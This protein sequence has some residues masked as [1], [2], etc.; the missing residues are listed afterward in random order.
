MNFIH[1][2]LCLI[3]AGYAKGRL[4]YIADSGQKGDDWRNKYKKLDGNLVETK[5]HWWYFG[6]Y[7]PKYQERF[8]FSTTLF[9]FLTDRWY[10]WQFAMLRYFYLAIAHGV[11]DNFIYQLILAFI[12]FPIIIG[13]T[14]NMVYKCKQTK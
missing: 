1:I 12:I 7:K 3:G 10:W 2:I 14:Y 5:S 9:R 6:L 13:V 4:D 8:P 11:A